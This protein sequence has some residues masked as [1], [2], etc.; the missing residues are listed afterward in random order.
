MSFQSNIADDLFKLI[1]PDIQASD[2]HEFIAELEAEITGKLGTCKEKMA[3]STALEIQR[4]VKA[5]EDKAAETAQEVHR[6]TLA[7]EAALCDRIAALKRHLKV[8][9]FASWALHL[10]VIAVNFR[11][12]KNNEE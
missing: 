2:K 9:H 10:R 6:L 8:W 3:E 5:A 7:R 4:R 12:R 11:R 1:L